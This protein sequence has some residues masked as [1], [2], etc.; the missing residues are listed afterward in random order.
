MIGG[1]QFTTTW[2]VDNLQLSHVDKKVVDQMIEWMKGL[3]G[4]GMRISR[5]NKH[6]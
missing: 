5:G 1:K 2:N 6:D 4:N 3:Y